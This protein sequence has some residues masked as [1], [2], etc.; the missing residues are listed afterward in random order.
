MKVVVILLNV[1]A[2]GHYNILLRKSM[3]FDLNFIQGRIIGLVGLFL[4]LPLGAYGIRE[5]LRFTSVS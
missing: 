1:F 5:T 3:Q 4:L 2:A